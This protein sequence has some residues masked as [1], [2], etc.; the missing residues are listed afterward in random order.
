MWD[1]IVLPIILNFKNTPNIEGYKRKYV[2][3]G[4]GVSKKTIDNFLLT[5]TSFMSKSRGE[6]SGSPLLGLYVRQWV[7]WAK[8]GIR[9]SCVCNT[10]TSSAGS[11]DDVRH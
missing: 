8:G 3:E 5:C 11:I 4:L 10:P 7:R 1:E 9:I 2:G 6:P